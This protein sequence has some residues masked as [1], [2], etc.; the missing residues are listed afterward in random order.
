MTHSLRKNIGALF[1][2]FPTFLD[3]RGHEDK[4]FVLTSGERMNGNVLSGALYS[5]DQ[6]C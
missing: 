6:S 5:T 3:E 1:Q 4:A 2:T